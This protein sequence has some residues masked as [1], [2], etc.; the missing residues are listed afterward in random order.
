MK[1]RLEDV[2]L[3]LAERQALEVDALR[4]EALAFGFR[5]TGTVAG[6]DSQALRLQSVLCHDWYASLGPHR[7][8]RDKLGDLRELLQAFA[9]QHLVAR[10]QF[11]L[12]MNVSGLAE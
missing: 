2:A 10:S 11:L 5:I 4:P 9:A 1:L 12:G 8:S 3:P 6:Y 7:Q